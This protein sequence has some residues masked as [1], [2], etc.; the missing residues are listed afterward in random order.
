MEMAAIGFGEAQIEILD[1]ATNFCRER[2]PIDKV[3]ELM[4]SDTGFDAAL[5]TEM[6]EL[7]WM[8]IAI[9]EAHG[10]I[11]LS[12]ADVVPVAEQMGRNMLSSPFAATTLAAQALL[13]GGEEAQQ[14]EWLP[15]LASGT[16]ATLALQEEHGDW[17]LTHVEAAANRDGDSITLSGKKLVVQWAE[18][19]EAIIATVSLDG[20]PALA[21]IT[22][23]DL[24]EG[25]LRREA[26]ID[27]T[28]RSAAV[29]L[30]GISIPESRLLDPARAG[31]ALV[32]IELASG[33]LQA[34]EMCGRTQSVIDY[35]V[36]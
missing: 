9:P 7:G 6:A 29:T 2:S 30:D 1:Q 15:K 32:H 34:A 18:A 25:A 8:G 14:A 13:A 11:G 3:R 10:G 5:W 4:D 17:D 21:L 28:K 36:D 35:T 12:L 19:A 27:E 20:A 24:P 16:I 23:A 31:S 33:V 22:K 26:I